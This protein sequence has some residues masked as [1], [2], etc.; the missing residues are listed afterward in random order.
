MIAGDN[1]TCD[2]FFADI[3]NTGEQLSLVT[4]T[5]AKT[6]Y[7]GVVDTG[8]KNAKS[9]KFMAGVYNTAEKLFSDV[10]DTAEKL[11]RGVNTTANKFFANVNNI[12]DKTVLTI[13]ACIDLKMKNKQKCNKQQ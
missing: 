7:H 6:F 8:Q 3:N 2:K 12:A 10:N 9:L 11:F 4:I 13:P 5:P 1:D